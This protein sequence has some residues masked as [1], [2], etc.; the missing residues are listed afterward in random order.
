MSAGKTIT[1]MIIKIGHWKIQYFL[2]PEYD[3]DLSQI[4]SLF[5]LLARKPTKT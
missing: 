5:F 3:P 2:Y 1:E 4:K